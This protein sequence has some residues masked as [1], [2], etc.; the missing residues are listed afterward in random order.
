MNISHRRTGALALIVLSLCGCARNETK[1]PAPKPQAAAGAFDPLTAFA[2]LVLPD[3]ASATRAADGTPGPA[4]WQNRADYHI[5]AVLDAA[6]ATL[7]VDEVIAYT[8]NSPNALAC[9]WLQLDQNAYKRDSRAHAFSTRAATGATDGYVI[10]SVEFAPGHPA[11]TVVSDARMQVRLPQALKAHAKL[12][13]H[14][15]YHF[16]VPGKFG[17]RMGPWRDEE[18]RDLRPPTSRNGIR[19]WRCTTICAAGTRCRTSR[20]V[21][22]GIRRLRLQRHRAVGHAGRRLRR[23]RQ[24]AGGS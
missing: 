11:E 13:L 17:G 4:Y 10:E 3:P 7:A 21:L 15:R 12:T 6:N 20:R 2:P 19:A 9:L 24:S 5:Q 1:K 8:N 22:P 18:R 23:A 16:T 14:I